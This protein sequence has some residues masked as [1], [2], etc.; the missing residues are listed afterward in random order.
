MDDNYL[1]DILKTSDTLSGNKNG[2]FSKDTFMKQ[3]EKY[4]E[5]SAINKRLEE[6]ARNA[7]K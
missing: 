5:P 6:E 2:G 1:D 7:L 4:H 3:F